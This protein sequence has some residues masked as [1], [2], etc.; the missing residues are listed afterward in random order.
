MSYKRVP[1]GEKNDKSGSKWTKDE[2]IEVYRLY[3][4]LNGVGIHENNPSI[5]KLAA[6]LGRTVRSTE[7]QALMFRNLDREGDY[8]FGNM[9]K[10]S[11]IVWSEFEKD[12]VHS[13]E[14]ST[15]KNEDENEGSDYSLNTFSYTDWNSLLINY[16]F[17]ELEENNEI[18][19]LLISPEIFKEIS[20]YQYDIEDFI[21][22]IKR[23]IGSRNFFSKLEASYKRSLPQKHNGKTI[24]KDKPE[25]FGFL[26][27][28]IFA[29]T[30]DDG[31][32]MSASNVYDRI[33]NF[34][35]NALG[36]RWAPLD[37]IISKKVL[38][39]AW[40][41]LEEWSCVF[42]K[43]KLGYFRLQNP[44]NPQ[45]KYVSRIERHALFNSHKFD[46]IIDLLIDDG[47]QPKKTLSFQEWTLFFTK[48][49]SK[50]NFISPILKYL[51]DDSPLRN[52]IVN[53][54]NEYCRNNITD[55]TIT[56]N[57]AKYRRPPVPLRLCLKLGFLP[58]IP[59]KKLY[60]RAESEFINLNAL[61]KALNLSE[62]F[63]LQT[64][65]VSE[66]INLPEEIPN[67]G[68]FE[69][70]GHRFYSST[71]KFYLVKDHELNEWRETDEISNKHSFIVVALE[72]E[73]SLLI[74]K[75]KLNYE[76]IKIENS[77][78]TAF[79]FTSLKREEFE[80][81]FNLFNPNVKQ[82][83][84]IELLTAFSTNR[85]KT[86]FIDLKP[87]FSYTGP[88]AQPV[89][90][91]QCLETKKTLC[92]LIHNAETERYYLPQKF[93]TP[94]EFRVCTEDESIKYRFYLNL[95][96]LHSNPINVT[97]PA[98]KNH[99]GKN[100]KE[101]QRTEK[102]IFD[103]PAN[104]MGGYD[105]AKFNSWHSNLFKI[106]KP[107]DRGSVSRPKKNGPIIPSKGDLLLFFLSQSRSVKTNDFPKLIRE[108]NPSISVGMS[109]RI[110]ENWRHLGY[111]NFYE[112]GETVRV[113]KSLIFFI[114]TNHGLRGMVS[115]HREPD[116]LEAL[117][118][119]SNE[120]EIIIEQHHHSN[121]YQDLYPSK[122]VL[123][124]R[125]GNVK[126]FEAL[127][128]ELS[129][130]YIN[131]IHNPLNPKYVVYQLASLFIQ[132]GCKDYIEEIKN[133]DLYPLDHNR[134][135]IFNP[136]SLKWEDSNE[137]IENFQNNTIVRF[138]GF[139]DRSVIHVFITENEPRVI[140]NL[141]LAIFSIIKHNVLHKRKVR[142]D[143]TFDFLVP[144]Y[145][146][147]PFWIERGLLLLNGMTPNLEKIDNV[148][149]RV[150]EQVESSV[151]EVIGQKL[152][153]NIEEL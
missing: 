129:L 149:F 122:I 34:G 44:L 101:L 98:L 92:K 106:F 118:N 136:V 31:I 151:L 12:H 116:F 147:L 128:D 41:Y 127:K 137:P 97:N 75:H 3:K 102:D 153:Q 1:G 40:T 76:L 61:K 110:M 73:M 24:R 11:R 141:P 139:I 86:I 148:Y 84:K 18:S 43:G 104:F 138:E 17:N 56:T 117:V 71:D 28:L 59:I 89:L 87:S 47:Y 120:N 54:L 66:E 91:A 62:D 4:E 81:I 32:D 48:Y 64:S 152:N 68:K 150:Y 111:I 29:L 69:F 107:A 2:I 46:Q 53:F 58:G 135:R 121:E 25:Y 83:G 15:L 99:N 33:N 114:K 45:R 13:S 72:N 65:Q 100:I 77:D 8:T 146:G 52:S 14:D 85:K 70:N 60:W 108:L 82:E 39:P 145:L 19:C 131:R 36:A 130:A 142:L 55:E 67:D 35:S 9:T 132:R 7:A 49:E 94:H 57:S 50:A 133:S 93:S 27:F 96:G 113:N 6:E 103:L 5:Q 134:K 30:E 78:F 119:Y 51:K 38:E 79:K 115:G 42:K 123:F 23:I 74:E 140:N 90:I 144:L 22:S 88:E 80:I 109:K 112:Y 143:R 63:I 37:S 21:I 124:D 126:K 125:D 16:Y 26:I 20:D 95:G 105:V 10:L